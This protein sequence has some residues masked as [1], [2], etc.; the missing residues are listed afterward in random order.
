MNVLMF[1]QLIFAKNSINFSRDFSKI[2]V[3]GLFIGSVF[4]SLVDL[5]NK[6]VP[7]HVY[8]HWFC[9]IFKS[10]FHAVQLQMAA[11]VWMLFLEIALRIIYFSKLWLVSIVC[12][13]CRVSSEKFVN[14]LF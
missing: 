1:F 3:R 10:L 8:S 2:S 14:F 9:R 11:S 5:N 12:N 13:V 4:I 6:W 7:T